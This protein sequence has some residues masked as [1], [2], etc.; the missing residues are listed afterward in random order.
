MGG[1]HRGNDKGTR[2]MFL[3]NENILFYQMNI[4]NIMLPAEITIAWVVN[5]CLTGWQN[6]EGN[7]SMKGRIH[8][9][10]SRKLSK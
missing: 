10:K 5:G 6:T 4:S 3:K 7:P 8:A 1:E 2:P 9:R